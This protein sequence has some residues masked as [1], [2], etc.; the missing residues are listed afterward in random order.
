M[1]A[2]ARSPHTRMHPTATNTPAHS[3]SSATSRR[4]FIVRPPV[5][6]VS[7]KGRL[8]DGG[9]ALDAGH[10]GA[11]EALGHER[12]ADTIR[13]PENRAAPPSGQGGRHRHDDSESN[14]DSGEIQLSPRHAKSPLDFE[15]S[16][17]VYLRDFSHS[18]TQLAPNLPRLSSPGRRAL[19]GAAPLKGGALAGQPSSSLPLTRT[20][21][22]SRFPARTWGLKGA[23]LGGH[24]GPL[25]PCPDAPGVFLVTF[26]LVGGPE[27]R[28]RLPRQ[29]PKERFGKDVSIEP[30]SVR[31]LAGRG[32]KNLCPAL[33]EESWLGARLSLLGRGGACKRV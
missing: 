6:M 7:C 4:R 31:I 29:I 10:D 9:D 2:R 18:L 24:R 1:S 32:L 17:P 33:G 19:A 20:C 21:P 11:A 15:S 26:A 27:T 14:P 28:S 30:I 22:P 16:G 8:R 12:L 13:D 23:R 25:L 3:G 5:K